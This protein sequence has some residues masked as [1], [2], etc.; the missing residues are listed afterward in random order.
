[1]LVLALALLQGGFIRLYVPSTSDFPINDGGLFYSMIR[2]LQNTHYALPKYASYNFSGI[3]F[4]Y[5][6]LCFYLGALTSDATG[7]AV[8]DILRLAPAVISTA[9]IPC[10]YF[11]SLDIL[12]S[13]SQAAVA[14][15]TFANLPRSFE[16]LIMGGGITRA[17]GFL[18]VL[19][20]LRSVYRYSTAHNRQDL[21]WSILFSSLTML[22]HPGM[23][24]VLMYLTF[25]FSLFCRGDIKRLIDPF[26]IFLGVL[27]LTSPWW[28]TVVANHGFAPLIS[29]IRSGQPDWQS[30]YPFV[31]L[32]FSLEY[33]LNIIG[34]LGVV[35]LLVS[36]AERK[37]LL[38]TWLL[39][40]FI[41]GPRSAFTSAT[42]PLAMLTGIAMDRIILPGFNAISSS[43]FSLDQPITESEWILRLLRS[44]SAKVALT[45]FIF[46]TFIN[47]FVYTLIGPAT[48]RPVSKE[49]RDAMQW[50]AENTVE[51]SKY[52]VITSQNTIWDDRVS[53]WFPVLANRNSV[54]T[55]QGF[56]WIPGQFSKKEEL[57]LS[58][59]T[60]ANQGVECLD[61]WEENIKS[62]YTHVFL[63]KM[64]IG[65][66]FTGT[67]VLATSLMSSSKYKEVYE[68]GGALLFERLDFH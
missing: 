18:F 62:G 36:L 66:G 17:I 20:A 45:F 38:T 49:N 30:L 24:W 34:V 7:W 42:V 27:S 44:R 15:L 47:A 48:L 52:L 9:T 68:S 41:V 64:D 46:Y 1:M 59:Q 63:S 6:P 11:L 50:I 35:G 3:P 16:W 13:K 21:V 39:S 57:Y 43:S 61:N 56:E 5:P 2:D 65:P 37:Y 40:V 33:A 54:A 31:S 23:A 28:L 10:F 19:L 32:N 22:S 4:A 29:G 53:E 58:L 8:E 67:E 12:K 51:S 26:I 14:A 25:L 60:C 55:V